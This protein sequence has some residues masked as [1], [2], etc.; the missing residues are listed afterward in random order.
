LDNGA[1]YLLDDFTIVDARTGGKLGVLHRE[2]HH[3]IDRAYIQ[4][5][6]ELW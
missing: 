5:H 4:Y 3:S 1:I 6:R 2:Y